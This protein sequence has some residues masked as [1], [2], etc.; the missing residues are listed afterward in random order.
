MDS[1]QKPI[2]DCRWPDPVGLKV[3]ADRTLRNYSPDDPGLNH[4]LGIRVQ[5]DLPKE[6]DG[7]VRAILVSPWAVERIHWCNPSRGDPPILHASPLELD[8]DGRVQAGIGVL[9]ECQGRRIPVLTAW[10]PELGHHFIETLL[11][12]VRDFSSPEEAIATA[13][14]HQETPLPKRS[15]SDHMNRKVSRRSLFGFLSS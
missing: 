12:T 14:G 4:R 13:L 10:E 7:P 3:A 6:A 2:W 11:H 9:L 5:M 1:E 8:S 15:V